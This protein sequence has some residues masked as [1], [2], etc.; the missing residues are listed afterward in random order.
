MLAS[1]SHDGSVRIWISNVPEA[2]ERIR[3]REHE[4]SQTVPFV[5][6]VDRG[7]SSSPV[8]HSRRPTATSE[9]RTY[10]EPMSWSHGR[11][12]IDSNAEGGSADFHGARE[13]RRFDSPDP[14]ELSMVERINDASTSSLKGL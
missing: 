14:V 3:P 10:S 13:I 8:P 2:K 9:G 1:A 5:L 11:A 12:S 7:L 4:S 6:E